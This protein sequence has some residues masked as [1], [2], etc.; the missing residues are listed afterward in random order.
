VVQL[1]QRVELS[2]VYITEKTLLKVLTRNTFLSVA[3]WREGHTGFDRN[4][5]L[6]VVVLF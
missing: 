1:C 5:S 4:C 6:V 2:L 3:V